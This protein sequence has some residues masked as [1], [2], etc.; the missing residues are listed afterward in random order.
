MKVYVDEKKTNIQN[1]KEFKI[2]FQN[3]KHLKIDFKE[4]T[5]K[6]HYYMNKK[7]INKI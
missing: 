3:L 5:L 6:Y 4:S 2:F 1:K 7:N